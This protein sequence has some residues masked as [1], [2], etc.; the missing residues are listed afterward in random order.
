LL[1]LRPNER[2]LRRFGAWKIA[3]TLGFGTRPHK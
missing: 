2:Q 1:P 3:T